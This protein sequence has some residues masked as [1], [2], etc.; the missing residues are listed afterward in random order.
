[1]AFFSKELAFST[2]YKNTVLGVYTVIEE[3][4]WL[5]SDSFYNTRKKNLEKQKEK[6]D[7]QKDI[8][9]SANI[10]EKL[11][12]LKKEHEGMREKMINKRLQYLD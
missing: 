8:I 7:R 3:L 4:Y 6:L 1:M 11:E 2:L 10:E 5:I 12:I 9:A